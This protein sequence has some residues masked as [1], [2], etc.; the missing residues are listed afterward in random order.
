MAAAMAAAQ[1][2][3][4]AAAAALTNAMGKDPA[5]IPPRVLGAITA[6]HPNVLIGGFPMA[7]IPNP[8]EMLLK[9]L[10]RYK[11]TPAPKP[12]AKGVGSCPA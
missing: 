2:A 11:R 1:M 8:A 9:R 7:N 3:A 12:Q 10:S 6:G 4:D 5:G